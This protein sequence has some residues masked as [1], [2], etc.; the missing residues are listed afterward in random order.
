V[1]QTRTAFFRLPHSI[2]VV[3][4]HHPASG[5]RKSEGGLLNTAARRVASKVHRPAGAKTA[6]CIVN[7][8]AGRDSS[9]RRRAIEIRTR[10]TH[11][12]LEAT[13]L[14]EDD[15]GRDQRG[16]RGDDRRAGALGAGDYSIRS[17]LQIAFFWRRWPAQ[18]RQTKS[19]SR[20]AAKKAGGPWA[21]CPD[22]EAHRPK[23]GGPA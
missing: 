2:R 22:R 21:Y 18:S 19:G 13:V 11:R 3:P 17:S 20:L 6:Q 12:A 15:A 5:S 8:G 1:I 10:E 7:A 16:P 14:I 4:D 23:A 9:L